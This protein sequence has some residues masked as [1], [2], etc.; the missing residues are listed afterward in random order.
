MS[1]L[2]SHFPES[3]LICLSD[4]GN[5]FIKVVKVPFWHFRLDNCR[6]SSGALFHCEKKGGVPPNNQQSVF[7]RRNKTATYTV[8]NLL[9]CRWA[10]VRTMKSKLEKSRL[11]F[12]TRGCSGHVCYTF[13]QLTPLLPMFPTHSQ[14]NTK[15]HIFFFIG[16]NFQDWL[17]FCYQAPF[18][19]IIGDQV[20]ASFR[21][22][23]IPPNVINCRPAHRPVEFRE[24]AQNCS[25]YFKSLSL[26]ACSVTASRL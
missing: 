4:D 18:S 16:G 11:Y 6:F 3:F 24:T 9:V 20:N 22:V 12:R 14:L 13:Y 26:W 21:L 5:R 8:S 17:Y 23:R 15:L 7:H 1:V 10:L 25:F 2:A 19:R